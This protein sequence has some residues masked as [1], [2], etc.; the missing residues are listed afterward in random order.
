MLSLLA[1]C[2]SGGGGTAE[3]FTISG[4]VTASDATAADGDVNDPFAPFASNDTCDTA[5]P[6]L[7]PVTLGGYVN[8]PGAGAPGR[9]FVSGDLDD[10]YSV[11]LLAG[12]TV[13]LYISED[14]S[15][16]DL[17]LYLID[18][19]CT[20]IIDA[21]LGLA[22][23][24]TVT[25]PADGEYLVNVKVYCDLADCS[26]TTTATNY[27]LVIGQVGFVA[28]DDLRAG[29]DFVSGEV[30]VTF[31]DTTGVLSTAQVQSR[32]RS[33]GLAMRAG[34]PGR[35]KLLRIDDAGNPA[36]AVSAIGLGK[37]SGKGTT[38]LG[39]GISAT[40]QEKL[41]TVT[42]VHALRVRPDVAAAD[43]N[44]IRRAF[45]VPDDDFY[46]LQWNYPLI[47][48]PAAWDVA[49]GDDVV[50]AVV[51]TGVLVDHPDLQ[52]Q[53]VAGY[54][55][56]SNP[57][58]AL[59]GDGIDD[60]PSD[61]GDGNGPGGSSSFHGTHV[62]GTIAARSDNGVGVAGVAW[63]AKIMPLRALGRFGAT[64]FDIQQ[65]VLYAAGLDN[66][67]GTV[68]PRRA[69]IINISLGGSGSSASEQNVY[70][71]ARDAGVIIVA[72]AGNASSTTP[73]YP[74]SYDGVISV[75][76][77]GINR[78]LA[79]YSNFGPLIDI[80]APGGDTSRDLNG[81]GFPD[82][83]LS[84]SGS[85][86]ESGIQHIYRFLQG[87]SMATAHVSGVLAL[88]KGIDPLLTPDD[89]DSLI[90]SGAITEDIGAPGRDDQFGWGLIDA[91]KAVQ[92]AGAAASPTPLLQVN[93]ASLNFSTGVSGLT[94]RLRNAGSGALAADAPVSDA[95]WLIV[96]ASDVDSNGLGTYAVAVDREGLAPGTYNATITIDSDANTAQI[97]V[98]MQV[99]VPGV[100][101]GDAGFHRIILLDPD[102]FETLQTVNADNVDGAYSFE[103]SGVPA[104]R[105]FIFAGTDMNNDS[106]IC[107][108]GEACGA[109][110]TISRLEELTV[111]ADVDNVNFV[112]SYDTGLSDA[113]AST[114]RRGLSR[115][116]V[117][118]MQLE[119]RP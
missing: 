73:A 22:P 101:G 116:P 20:T 119:G 45:R 13:T 3:L 62:A 34:A 29:D 107:G 87:T 43:L 67:S 99:A 80:A 14:G 6:L 33:M 52:G 2:S 36:V 35:A 58:N 49:L 115:V 106:F 42:I 77:V 110:P 75:S 97:P 17:D 102:T 59:D 30:I 8:T 37:R 32:A 92:A 88:M 108:E 4:T 54:D 46:H 95:D 85:E 51:D 61:P 18:S 41:D 47:N 79:P 76:A 69:D 55:F 78:T 114:P 12:Q 91:F 38:R 93:P 16:H 90:S 21:S 9:S 57:N 84:L 86:G 71:Q 39:V 68:P 82:G 53:L 31:D 48:L 104:G 72:A 10:V 28:T 83:V 25:A 64:S 11:A 27:N 24:E 65:A 66:A 44:Y 63:N 117:P 98:S 103:F 111:S 19:A 50:V 118:V 1:A 81:D 100:T 94:L 26:S 60:D 96:S 40:L 113:S 109:W 70:A 5:Q 23:I 7:N 105:Y 56:I 15:I 89:I 74:A 112:T